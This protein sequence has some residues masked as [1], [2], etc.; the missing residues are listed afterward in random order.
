[1]Q[2]AENVHVAEDKLLDAIKGVIQGPWGLSAG[3]VEEAFRRIIERR[4]G[5]S[6]ARSRG[7]PKQW[8]KSK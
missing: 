7:R 8:E 6:V 4:Y 5:I 3:E 2:N 1:M